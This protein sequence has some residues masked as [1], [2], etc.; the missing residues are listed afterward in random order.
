M[1]R[2]SLPVIFFAAALCAACASVPQAQDPV[3]VLFVGNSLTYAGNLPAVVDAFAATNGQ[4][5]QSDMIAKGGATLT[6]HLT[7]GSVESA[8]LDKRYDYVVLQERGGDFICSFGPLSCQDAEASLAQLTRLAEAHK[9]EVILLGTY[10]RLASVSV[11]LVEAETAVARRLSITHI[12]VSAYFQAGVTSRHQAEWLNNDGTHPGHDLVL[13][14]AMLLYRHLF[15]VVPDS[16]GF[17]V[18][19]PMQGP[20]SQIAS[21]TYTADRVAVVLGIAV[22]TSP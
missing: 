12:P 18:H 22:G 11:A 14:N 17:S 16:N 15:G 13:L 21:H 4:L 2:I 19:A 6:Q 3:R 1:R 8:L 10:Q 20:S 9:A 7:D 5:V